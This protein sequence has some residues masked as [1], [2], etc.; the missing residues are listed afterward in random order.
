MSLN[1]QEFTD[2][3]NEL[4]NSARDVAAERKHQQ[5]GTVAVFFVCR[6]KVEYLTSAF[7]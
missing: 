1:P 5:V 2:K 6:Q 7:L 3:T 4:L